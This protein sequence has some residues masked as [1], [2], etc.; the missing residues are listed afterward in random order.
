MPAFR[1]LARNGR[2]DL[3][4]DLAALMP[5]IAAIVERQGQPEALAEIAQAVIDVGRCWS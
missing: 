5:W 4:G 3:L 1:R 2:P